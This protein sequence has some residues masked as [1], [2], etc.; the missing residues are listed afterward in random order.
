MDPKI[1]EQ[2]LD[3]PMPATQRYFR[4]LTGGPH[5]PLLKLEY[6][7]AEEM[8]GHPEYE[9]VTADGER[10]ADVARENAPNRI[11]FDPPVPPTPRRPVLGVPKKK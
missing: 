1:A 5:A 3:K 10:V 8:K 11:R 9:E 2:Y 4:C 6:W 7:E